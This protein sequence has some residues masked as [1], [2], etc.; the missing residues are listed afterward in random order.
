MSPGISQENAR[1]KKM[2]E[3]IENKERNRKK[4]LNLLR[5]RICD[6]F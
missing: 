4:N 2:S 5:E 6:R 1:E 3:K